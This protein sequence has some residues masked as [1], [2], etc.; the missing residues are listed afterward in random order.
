MKRLQNLGEPTYSGM[1]IKA[2]QLWSNNQKEGSFHVRLNKQD[3]ILDILFPII[4][5]HEEERPATTYLG[6]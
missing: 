6:L 5:I 2:N 4:P 1:V 3:N